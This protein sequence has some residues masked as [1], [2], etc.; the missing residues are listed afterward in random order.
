[1]RLLLSPL[2]IFFLSQGPAFAQDE[3]FDI[4]P[5][6]PMMDDFDE[7]MVEEIPSDEY[8]DGPV[9]EAP[10]DDPAANDQKPNTLPQPSNPSRFGFS[11]PGDNNNGARPSF[12]GRNPRQGSASPSGGGSFGETTGKVRFEIVDG[13]FWEKGKKRTRGEK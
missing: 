4:P 6:P 9:Y 1:M 10:P 7:D 11:G 12:R 13:V 8:I 2:I 5:P 3:D